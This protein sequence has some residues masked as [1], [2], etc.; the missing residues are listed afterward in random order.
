[1]MK[2]NDF[3]GDLSRI[4][5]ITAILIRAKN[6]VSCASLLV[7][8]KEAS[9]GRKEVQMVALAEELESRKR[10]FVEVEQQLATES[11][12]RRRADEDVAVRISRP[13]SIS[14]SFFAEL[15]VRSPRKCIIFII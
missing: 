7:Q 9:M 5:P 12:K 6:P 8:G 4:S 15:S 1:M 14:A 11:Q 2:I 10:S 13:L 3:R